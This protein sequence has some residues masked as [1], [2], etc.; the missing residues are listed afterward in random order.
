[1][2]EEI[3]TINNSVWCLDSEKMTIEIIALI[4]WTKILDYVNAKPCKSSWLRE[5]YLFYEINEYYFQQF[6]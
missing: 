6:C 3:D 5:R 4:T 1:M 2:L